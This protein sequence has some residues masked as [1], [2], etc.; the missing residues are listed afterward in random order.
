[1]P[2]VAHTLQIWQPKM[3][4]DIA[5]CPLGH[6]SP[7]TVPWGAVLLHW[8]ESLLWGRVCSGW[9]RRW[10]L[11]TATDWRKGHLVGSLKRR[12]ADNDNSNSSY[13]LR[14]SSILGSRFHPQTC[15]NV[16]TACR[17]ESK[18]ST[19]SL[20]HPDTMILGWGLNLGH[21]CSFCCSNKDYN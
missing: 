15:P 9:H 16:T 20:R 7:F 1:M 11:N 8:V 19:V 18:D 10:G 17:W 4:P 21:P 3:P 13:S 14:A 5:S 12:M 2:I 6:C